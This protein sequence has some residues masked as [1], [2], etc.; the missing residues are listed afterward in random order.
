MRQTRKILEEYIAEKRG[1]PKPPADVAET[2][3]RIVRDTRINNGAHRLWHFL[4]ESAVTKADGVRRCQIEQVA[5]KAA[6]ACKR[7]SVIKWTRD[8][9]TW[10]YLTV[11]RRHPCV[12]EIRDGLTPEPKPYGKVW[13]GSGEASP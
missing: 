7:D 8:L 1:K 6:L 13:N 4:N 3:S 10:G 9:M 5:I 2:A 11:L 12:Y